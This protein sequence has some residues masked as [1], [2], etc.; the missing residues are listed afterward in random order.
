M[1]PPVMSNPSNVVTER[2]RVRR[3]WFIRQGLTEYLAT[4]RDAD[5]DAVLVVFSVDQDA[6]VSIKLDLGD[7]W[8]DEAELG[9]V[10]LEHR[11]RPR[12]KVHPK[13]VTQK[14]YTTLTD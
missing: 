2:I 7:G 10:W 9:K 1:L 12:C 14:R 6:E 5:G 4:G 11:Q 3:E 8:V 13:F